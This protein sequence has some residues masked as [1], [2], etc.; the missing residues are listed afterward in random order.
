MKKPSKFIP[1]VE[2]N[3]T[4]RMQVSDK[5]LKT[6]RLIKASKAASIVGTK[7][8]NELVEVLARDSQPRTASANDGRS[9]AE[10]LSQLHA[11]ILAKTQQDAAVNR[12]LA[13][14]EP[15]TKR[16][17]IWGK[18]KSHDIVWIA[19][20]FCLIICFADSGHS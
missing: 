5:A 6:A 7:R 13:I 8:L 11:R 10:R 17:R 12:E 14:S 1:V 4:I 19:Q 16:F 15:P 2:S 18:T 3:A 9:A 20:V